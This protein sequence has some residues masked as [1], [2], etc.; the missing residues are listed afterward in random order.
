[1]GESF[2]A[3]KLNIFE[4]NL[5][6]LLAWA[7]FLVEADEVAEALRLLEKG[8]PG[9]YRDFQNP[10]IVELKKKIQ[11]YLMTS[12]DY[13]HN[14]KDEPVTDAISLQIINHVL[15]GKLIF[16]SVKEYNANGITPHIVDMGPGDYWLALGLKNKEVKFT[17]QPFSM[18]IAAHAKAKERL[19]DHYQESPTG[20]P[21]IF[22]ACEIIEHL[23]NPFE[24]AQTAAKL[25]QTPDL[26]VLSTP[27]Y[28]FDQGRENWEQEKNVGFVCHIK[29]FTPSEFFT[30][31]QRLFSG[32][33]WEYY[34][35][36]VMVLKGTLIK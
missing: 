34:P 3:G 2:T 24:I 8:I 7:S 19:G 27:L 25:V 21:L 30:E 9:Y 23:W 32:Y 16:E 10:K 18:Q 36:V 17:Y 14:D 35:D 15:R 13:I 29:T 4:E 26:I 33:N 1:M 22:V 28:T 12:V 31:A 6:H 5:P 20:A 11:R